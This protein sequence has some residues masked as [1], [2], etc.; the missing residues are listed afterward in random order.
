MNV[1]ERLSAT[2]KHST[3]KIVNPPASNNVK[4]GVSTKQPLGNSPVGGNNSA[5]T[6]RRRNSVNT[7][8]KII[9]E[10]DAP[11]VSKVPANDISAKRDSQ[12]SMNPSGSTEIRRSSVARTPAEGSRIPRPAK[13]LTVSELRSKSVGPGACKK[14]S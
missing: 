9:I 1:F 7:V 8:K 3:P 14:S 2:P 5:Q 10:D 6:V 11:A 13:V 12:R 4:R